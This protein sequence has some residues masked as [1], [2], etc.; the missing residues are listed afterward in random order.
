VAGWLPVFSMTGVIAFMAAH[1]KSWQ[2]KLI[3]TSAVMAFIPILN[4]VYSAFNYSYYARW[5]YMPLLVMVL[6][7]VMG[8]EDKKVDWTKGWRWTTAITLL[9]V[10]VIGFF[11]NGQNADGSFTRFGLFDDDYQDRFIVTSSIAVISLLLMLFLLYV[12]KRW[13]KDFARSAIAVVMLI[14]IVYSSYCVGLGQK[15]AYDAKNFIIP[16]LLENNRTINLENAY[17]QVE[18][19]YDID[20]LRVDVYEGMDNIGMFLG[21]GSVHAFH[22][23]VPGSIMEFY[24]F[25][26]VKR[27]VATRAETENYALRGL[28]SVKYV[29]DYARDTKHFEDESGV[30]EMPG[31]SVYTGNEAVEN[32]DKNDFIQNDYYIYEND[33][34]VPYGFTYD[35]YVTEKYLKDFEETDRDDMMLKAMLLTKEQI[36][37][38]GD[39]MTDLADTEEDYTDKIDNDFYFENCKDRAATA[40]SSF[41]TDQK[42]FTAK[43]TLQKD[44]LVFFS[45]PYDEGWTA[46]ID[47]NAVEIEKVNAGF[48]AVKVKGDGQEHEIRFDYET[49][50]LSTGII[51]SVAAL[52]LTALF[53]LCIKR[54]RRVDEQMVKDIEE[55]YFPVL[56][57]ENHDDEVFPSPTEEE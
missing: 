17:G 28:L 41:V 44:N 25:V 4:S 39:L 24:D 29:L 40:C 30:P 12:K 33:Y 32:P 57:E 22:S 10:M 34:F 9:F 51:I 52:I 19:T 8:L 2:K 27:T 20:D 6:M 35:Y 53:L 21:I 26:G 18:N 45:V 38:Y 23:V 7:T 48:M 15:S 55:S 14:S 42:G 54:F 11:P 47:G 43:T 16:V 46:T 50:G 31:F 37:K 13:S 49:P 3:V 56:P 1:K 36:A 5:F